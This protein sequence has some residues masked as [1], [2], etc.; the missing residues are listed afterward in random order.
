MDG[1]VSF[2]GRLSEK[3]LL[4]AY[5]RADVFLFPNAPQT[6]GLAVFEAMAM[7]C[8]PVITD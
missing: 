6:W 1:K 2:L 7:G 4:A 5:S 8:V 3:D